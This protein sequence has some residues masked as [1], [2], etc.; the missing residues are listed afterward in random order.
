VVN[1]TAM[2]RGVW[3]W[4]SHYIVQEKVP[5][6]LWARISLLWIRN[7]DCGAGTL[8]DRFPLPSWVPTACSGSWAATGGV[9]D[10]CR[11]RRRGPA[12]GVLRFGR[13]RARSGGAHQRSPS[14]H[15]LWDL[16]EVVEMQ[17][18]WP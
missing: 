18:K 17:K 6:N 5:L 10:Q 9:A 12:A 15:G 1:R 7:G 14:R 4:K 3:L 13:E 8:P 11:Q 16:F 2:R